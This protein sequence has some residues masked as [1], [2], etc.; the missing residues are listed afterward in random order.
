MSH[1]V[2]GVSHPQHH[3]AAPHRGAEAQKHEPKPVKVEEPKGKLV[4]VKG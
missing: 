3:H 1:A 2:G 4:D